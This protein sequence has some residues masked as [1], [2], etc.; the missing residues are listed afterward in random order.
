LDLSPRLPSHAHSTGESACIGSGSMSLARKYAIDN[1]RC[2]DR[3]VCAD[4]YRE[5]GFQVS[6]DRSGPDTDYCL[7]GRSGLGF[8]HHWRNEVVIG[9]H[10]L[11]H[12][13]R[14]S[15]L[16]I[17]ILRAAGDVVQLAGIRIEIV[18]LENRSRT[19]EVGALMLGLELARLV[20]GEHLLPSGVGAA[21]HGPVFHLRRD[22]VNQLPALV[23][24]R[25]GQ[26]EGGRFGF[27]PE[28]AVS[29]M[30]PCAED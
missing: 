22:V 10:L 12:R 2:R 28:T 15:L 18:E 29:V 11:L 14:E 4:E 13:R 7:G 9:D 30:Q 27:R 21:V 24:D 16:D 17:A 25:A 5:L 26:I 8:G 20:S 3:Y 19:L 23:A 1:H 6:V